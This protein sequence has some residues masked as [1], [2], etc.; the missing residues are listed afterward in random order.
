MTTL[1]PASGDENHPL[2]DGSVDVKAWQRCSGRVFLDL[3]LLPSGISTY[4][5]GGDGLAR[6]RSRA[7]MLQVYCAEVLCAGKRAEALAGLFGAVLRRSV[8]TA[9]GTLS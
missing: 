8:Y 5:L 9:S 3:L 6:S 7:E 1:G 4:C 2:D